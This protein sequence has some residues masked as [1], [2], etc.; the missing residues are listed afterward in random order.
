MKRKLHLC[1][2]QE[3]FVNKGTLE[4]NENLI[5]ELKEKTNEEVVKWVDVNYNKLYVDGE[6]LELSY[7]QEN[8]EYMI[9]LS[10]FTDNSELVYDKINQRKNFFVC[11][12]EL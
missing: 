7:F 4:I 9:P 3:V 5:P 10:T 1:E 12:N 11:E 6:K 8:N 2:M